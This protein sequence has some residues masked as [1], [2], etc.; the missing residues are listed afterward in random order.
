M[1]TKSPATATTA[2]TRTPSR[3]TCLPR[4]FD[5]DTTS[6]AGR[7]LRRTVERLISVRI[8]PETTV[9]QSTAQTAPDRR[10]SAA[11][12]SLHHR[13]RRTHSRQPLPRY[14]DRRSCCRRRQRAASYRPSWAPS[15]AALRAAPHMEYLV[16]D[17]ATRHRRL[18]RAPWAS[19]QRSNELRGP[20]TDP[21]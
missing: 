11:H 1:A 4:I 18:E 2:G 19:Q 14:R 21:P 20:R 3:V 10:K 5:F 17:P 7:S 9:P 16:E 13:S 6:S 12:I 15:P 8:T